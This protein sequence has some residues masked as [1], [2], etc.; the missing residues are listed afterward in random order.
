[1]AYDEAWLRNPQGNG[2]FLSS[3]LV[4]AYAASN[5]APGKLCITSDQ[6]VMV[7]TA[8]GVWAP[9]GGVLGSLVSLSPYSPTVI[10]LAGDDFLPAGNVWSYVDPSVSFTGGLYR[11]DNLISYAVPPVYATD[12]LSM[13]YGSN[14]GSYHNVFLRAQYAKVTGGGNTVADFAQ[15]EAAASGAHAWGMNSSGVASASGANSISIEV[16]SVC[17]ASG[18]VSYGVVCVAIGT[19][20]SVNALQIQG[21]PTAAFGDGIF[22]NSTSGAK[23]VTGSLLNSSLNTAC[24][25]GMRFRGTYSVNEIITPQFQVSATPTSPNCSLQITTTPATTPPTV[26]L[27][28]IGVGGSPATNATLLIN[29]LGTGSISLI[30]QNGNVGVDQTGNWYLSTPGGALYIA[31]GTG[32][33][34]S[35]IATL[36][37]GT[38]T[39]NNTQVAANSRIQLTAQS[40][41]TVTS[42]S[43]LGVSARTPGTSFTILASQ[44]NDTSTVAW[45][46]V[47]PTT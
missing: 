29:A 21:N 28:A 15:G 12:L 33:C 35:G 3:Q 13:N 2:V 34:S 20:P 46:I 14:Y 24:Q 26:M 8:T 4:G 10:T 9:L 44:S 36:V 42:P 22:F 19:Q 27:N 1:V 43:A 5:Y 39:V 30:T 25:Y 38:V 31:E 18:G 45:F 17:L 32:G 16:D 47:Q 23:A 6:G 7:V 37:A 41:G 11:V 40:L